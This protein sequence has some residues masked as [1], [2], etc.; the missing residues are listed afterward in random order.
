VKI[1]HQHILGFEGR[2]KL[3]VG[4]FG[5][6]RVLTLTVFEDRCKLP[7]GRFGVEGAATLS[8]I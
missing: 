2:C 6:L 5:D 1:S 4:R 7:V 3:L 8:G